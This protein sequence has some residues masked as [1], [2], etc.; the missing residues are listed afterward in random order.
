MLLNVSLFL[1]ANLS[2]VDLIIRP[3]RR[4]LRVQDN[5]FLPNIW[6]QHSLFMPHLPKDVWIPSE[7][8]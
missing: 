4:T 3:A 6:M 5:F 2:R 7:F 8:W 1:S